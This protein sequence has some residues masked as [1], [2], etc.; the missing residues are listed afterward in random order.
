MKNG[1]HVQKRFSGELA[2][3]RMET[4]KGLANIDDSMR[5]GGVIKSLDRANELRR[6]N[7]TK[8]VVV[9]QIEQ[10]HKQL[11]TKNAIDEKA[12]RDYNRSLDLRDAQR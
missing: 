2:S 6:E 3:P 5:F 10:T 9:P 12:I 11:E 7:F 4:P 8:N 1:S